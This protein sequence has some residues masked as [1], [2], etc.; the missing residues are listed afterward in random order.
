MKPSKS[1]KAEARSFPQHC[2]VCGLVAPDLL[3]FQ[4]DQHYVAGNHVLTCSPSCRVE[5]GFKERKYW[6]VK[7]EELF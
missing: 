3:E 6:P 1:P 7:L 5:K 4:W 2:I